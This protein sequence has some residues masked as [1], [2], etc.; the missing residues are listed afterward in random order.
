MR[1]SPSIV[2]WLLSKIQHRLSRLQVPGERGRLR[3]D[4]LH[5]AAVP[6][7]RVG[8]VAEDLEAGLVVALGQ[9]LLR[10]GHA[11]AGG[12]ALA[13]RPGRG[14]HPGHPAVLRVARGPAVELAEVADVVEGHRGVPEPLVLG[15]DRARA[16]RW[17]TDQSSIEAWPLE[18]TKRS[19]LGQI[20][21]SGIEAQHAVPEGVDQRRQGHRRARVAGLRRLHR[22]DRER[23]DGVDGELVQL[24]VR[25]RTHPSRCPS[26]RAAAA[27]ARTRAS[28]GGR[29]PRGWCG[30]RRAVAPA[31]PPSRRPSPARGHAG[32]G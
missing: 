12:H 13:E 21:S 22:V 5:Q 7:D 20:G 31:S 8:L 11:H 25:H 14:L 23:A 30:L 27:S 28:S 16:R 17:S 24:L 29:A 9:P 4:A 1:V 32:R 18:R 10:D 15:V 19:R 6:A 26:A 3:G 2:M